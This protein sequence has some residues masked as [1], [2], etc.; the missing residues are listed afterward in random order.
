MAVAVGVA[1]WMGV[2]NIGVAPGPGYYGSVAQIVPVLLVA[3]AVERRSSS[4][5]GAL[6]AGVYRYLLFAA[7]GLAELCAVVAASGAFA[8]PFNERRVG[9]TVLRSEMMLAAATIGLVAGFLGVLAIA[10]WPGQPESGDGEEPALERA[11]APAPQA[12]S[13][14]IPDVPFSRTCREE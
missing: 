12:A 6:P 3:L 11:D 14:R 9:G 7:L 4:V 10:V 2:G 1:V 13:P 8:D 5:F